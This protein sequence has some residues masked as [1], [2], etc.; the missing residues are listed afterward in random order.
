MALL[1]TD[2]LKGV[3]AL[4]LEALLVPLLHPALQLPV[5]LKGL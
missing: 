5:Y 3:L 1:A 2:Q 4:A